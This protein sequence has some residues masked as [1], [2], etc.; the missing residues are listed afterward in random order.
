MFEA[1]AIF[2]RQENGIAH[3]GVAFAVPVQRM[4]PAD[5][6]GVMFTAD[7]AA[8][9]GDALLIEAVYGLGEPLVSGE[10]TPDAYAVSRRGLRVTNR[11]LAVQ[12]WMLRRDPSGDGFEAGS[13]RVLVSRA[14]EGQ[15]K[16]DDGHVIALAE[17][18]LRLE[19][20]YGRPQDV[21]W[22]WADGMPYVLQSRPITTSLTA[23]AVSSNGNGALPAIVSGAAA[24]L[25]IA[26]GPIRIIHSPGEIGLVRQGD[27]LVT[28]MTTPD[29]VPAMKRAAAIV[30][31]RGGR[32]CHA[33]I[34][35]PNPPKEGVGLAS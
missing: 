26:A 30:T 2:Y 27:V 9:D 11:E 18:G 33:A 14:L 24:S 6:S 35:S 7:P 16:L 21:E 3:T 1:R 34:V 31:D 23:P 15:P 17:L 19:R 22:A 13:E 10:L 8:G 29:F 12:P 25:G 20:R 28:E 4:V 32:T 5:V